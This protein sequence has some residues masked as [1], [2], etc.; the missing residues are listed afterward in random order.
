MRT[1]T[2]GEKVR[3]Q[4]RVAVGEAGGGFEHLERGIAN[5]DWLAVAATPEFIFDKPDA[6]KWADA[7]RRFGIEITQFSGLGGS[8]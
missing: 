4:F 6:V 8:A 7:A 2:E 1:K 3:T 5:G